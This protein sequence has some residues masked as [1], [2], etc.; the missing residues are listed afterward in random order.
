MV[1][2]VFQIPRIQKFPNQTQK[3]FVLDAFRQNADHHI[4]VDVV[5]ESLDIP[6]DKPFYCREAVFNLTEC[7]MTAMV[8][9]ETMGDFGE[10][11]FINCFKQ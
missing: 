8:G 1:L 6:L 4:V 11:L 10:S 9:S 5:K 2:P 3:A 7:C